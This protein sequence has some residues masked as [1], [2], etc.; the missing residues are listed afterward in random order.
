MR[1]PRISVSKNLRSAF[2]PRRPHP[3][4]EPLPFQSRII[5]A[6]HPKGKQNTGTLAESGVIAS[7]TGKGRSSVPEGRK[8][9]PSRWPT[10]FEPEEQLEATVPAPP[11]GRIRVWGVIRG[12]RSP[13]S[14]DRPANLC[15]PFGTKST[16]A[17]LSITPG[18]TP[19]PVAMAPPGWLSHLVH[20]GETSARYP[21]RHPCRCGR[22]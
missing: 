18:G 21:G 4:L 7:G 2:Q 8:I 3:P 12:C 16:P 9:L 6:P 17:P 14:L 20:S 15:C 1:S 5:A 19:K 22:S 13:D 10:R 11:P